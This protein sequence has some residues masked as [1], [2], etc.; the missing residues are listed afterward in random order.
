MIWCNCVGV[1]EE[2]CDKSQFVFKSGS[3]GRSNANVLFV[4]VIVNPFTYLNQFNIVRWYI[5]V[6][7]VYFLH[8]KDLQEHVQLYLLT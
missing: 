2:Q 4:Y 1:N 5:L 3:N 8:E 6:F 7:F